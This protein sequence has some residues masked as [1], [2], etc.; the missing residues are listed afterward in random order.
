M[1]EILRLKFEKMLLYSF[2]RITK[3]NC[4]ANPGFIL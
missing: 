2:F 3:F 1:E 4:I